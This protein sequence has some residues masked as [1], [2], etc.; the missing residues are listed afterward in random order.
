[1]S[2]QVLMIDCS[3][4]ANTIRAH[5]CANIR[6]RRTAQ[7]AHLVFC[8][9]PAFPLCFRAMGPKMKYATLITI[10]ILSIAV[11]TIGVS[12]LISQ[13]TQNDPMPQLGKLETDC[14]CSVNNATR[15]DRW[16]IYS[17]RRLA[18][19]SSLNQ[20]LLSIAASFAVVSFFGLILVMKIYPGYVHFLLHLQN[21]NQPA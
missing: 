16:V 19:Q 5:S 15:P 9:N 21:K 17:I 4:P 18:A 8:R 3:L 1:M 2:R 20:V 6:A 14:D 10:Y 11:V 13:L 12:H 7:P